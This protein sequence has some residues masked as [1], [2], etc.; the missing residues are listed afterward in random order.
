MQRPPLTASF[1]RQLPF[2][3]AVMWPWGLPLT[4]SFAVCN[5][6]ARHSSDALQSPQLESAA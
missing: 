2:P 1:P 3:E 4:V 5:L 6:I